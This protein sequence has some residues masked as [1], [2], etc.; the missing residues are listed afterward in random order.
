M[1]SAS[2]NKSLVYLSVDFGPC[3]I[4]KNGGLSG[5]GMELA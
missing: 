2:Q 4:A 3:E 5:E 1:P